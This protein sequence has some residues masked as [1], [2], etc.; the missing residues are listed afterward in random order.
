RI[1]IYAFTSRNE[2]FGLTLI[3]AMAAG[4]AVV[5]ARA[6]AAQAV[7]EDGINGILVPPADVD[8]L[9]A[10]LEPLMRNPGQKAALG[11]HACRRVLAQFGIDAEVKHIVAVY[12]QVL[13]PAP[14]T[15]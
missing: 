15:I 14:G 3:E 6:G 10:A 13:N 5:A 4:T 8:A 11:R 7:I 2:G 12:R 1:A 9:I